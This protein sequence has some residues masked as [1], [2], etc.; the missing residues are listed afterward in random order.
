MAPISLLLLLLLLLL[1]YHLILRT[2]FILS[3][4]ENFVYELPKVTKP[5]LHLNY[6]TG[7]FRRKGQ[8]FGR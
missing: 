8:Y 6:Y 1:L 4:S 3:S 2:F 5:S 7:C